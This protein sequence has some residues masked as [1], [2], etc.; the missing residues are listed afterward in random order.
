[1][2]QSYSAGGIILNHLNQVLLVKQPNGACTFP[3][4]RIEKNETELDAA[5][6]EI[7][8]ET[9]ITE[10]KLIKQ[11]EPY[12]RHPTD[13]NGREIASEIRTISL[14][15]FSTSQPEL[16]ANDKDQPLWVSKDE[17]VRYL[18]FAIE[19]KLFKSLQI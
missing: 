7:A 18:S 12:N 6:R 14:Y 2:K 19:Q 8:E 1:M 3:K 16:K 9:G 5:I 11:L 4:G 17:V 15:I 13:Q 10:L